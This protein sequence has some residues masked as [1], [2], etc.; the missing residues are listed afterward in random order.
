MTDEAQGSALTVTLKGGGDYNA[1][2]IVVR[3]DDPNEMEHY[4]SAVKERLTTAV[5]D[6]ARSFHAIWNV[7]DGLGA[8]SVQPAPQAQPQA[9]AAPASP[10]ES[11]PAAP[12]APAPAA[13]PAA[14]PGSSE[15]EVNKY[16]NTYEWGHPQA[17]MTPGGQAVLK[18]ATSRAGKAY[19]R[20]IDPRSKEIPSVYAAGTRQDPPDLWPGDFANGV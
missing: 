7:A 6:A 2:W 10:W 13:A 3:A 8:S 9:P 5:S 12:A 18:R 16:G 15:P 1:P 4:L 14:Q 20:W 11:A 19:A 17:P